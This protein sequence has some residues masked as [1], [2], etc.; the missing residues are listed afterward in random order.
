MECKKI[1]HMKYLKTFENTNKPNIGDYVV[2]NVKDEKYYGLPV[3]GQIY[4]EYPNMFFNRVYYFIKYTLPDN[5]TFN[6]V[7]QI[8]EILKYSKNKENLEY[9]ISSNKYNI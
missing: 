6:D 4:A 5:H 1:Q 3:I 8:D 9:I 2:V 7:F